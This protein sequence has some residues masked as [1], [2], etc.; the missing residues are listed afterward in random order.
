M[1]ALL[2]SCADRTSILVEVS[3]PLVI[4]DDIDQLQVEIVGDVAG[5]MADRTFDL[6]TTWP[7][8]VSIRP[9][10]TESQAITVRVTA[11]RSGA[12]VARRVARSRFVRGE[13]I[14]VRVLIDP[15]CDGVMCPGNQDCVGGRCVD[16]T[17]LDGG[18]ADG[19]VDAGCQSTLDC[20]DSVP[21]TTDVCDNGS[22]THEPD[23]SLCQKGATCDV[24]AGCPPRVCEN[25][26]QCNDGVTCNGNEV[27]VGMTCAPGLP[28][29]CNDADPCTTDRCDE[30][31][32]GV[33]VSSTR[34]A[35][36]D[37]FGD[38]A[39]PEAGG[40]PA[41]DCND[42]NAD[43]NPDAVEVCNGTDDDCNGTCDEPATCCRGEIGA[44]MSSCGTTGSRVCGASCAWG[45]CSPPAEQ[46][47]AVD[48]DCNGAA[49]DIFACVQG[50]SEGCTTSCGSMGT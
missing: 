27:C 11:R 43:A 23:D 36:G 39:C 2:A 20:D 8:S 6:M 16:I 4:P 25:D 17:P 34:D 21:C 35:D 28:V 15:L 30:G 26:A 42:G 47:N 24:A 22:C 32:R 48:D 38:V 44:C 46:C 10:A 29:D 5:G 19:R 18:V 50:T 45:V 7:H 41:T 31:M 9:G 12:F 1:A 37:G 33:C 14:V 40:V 3:S 49:D 13:Q